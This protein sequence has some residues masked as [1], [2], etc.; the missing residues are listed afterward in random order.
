M[1]TRLAILVEVV[2]ATD[3]TP[4]KWKASVEPNSTGGKRRSITVGDDHNNPE[5]AAAIS[6]IQ[7]LGWGDGTEIPLHKGSLSSSAS[8][9][10]Y[11]NPQEIY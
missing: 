3:T 1:A 10:V 4:R 11:E 8:V 5:L 9:F 6:L 2:E 7:K